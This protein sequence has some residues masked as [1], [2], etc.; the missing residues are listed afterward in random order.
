MVVAAR[1]YPALLALA[2]CAACSMAAVDQTRSAP[3]ALVAFEDAKFVPV[4]SGRFEVAV[5]RG[6]PQTGPSA[7]F[8]RFKKGVIPMHVHVSDYQ[9]IVVHGQLKRWNEQQTEDDVKAIGPGS[10]IFEPAE[11][12]HANSCVTDECLVYI[13]WSG[14][15]LTRNVE[16]RKQ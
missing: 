6:D 8:I 11:Q 7:M 16:P 9:L 2:M 5:L 1:L 3:P 15:Q 14:K 13:V 10:Y 4:G 12:A